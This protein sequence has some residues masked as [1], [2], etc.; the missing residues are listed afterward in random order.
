MFRNVARRVTMTAAVP[1]L[2]LRS[3]TT[4]QQQAGKSSLDPKDSSFAAGNENKAG[5]QP[6]GSD[7][8]LKSGDSLKQQ[9]SEGPLGGSNPKDSNFGASKGLKDDKFSSTSSSGSSGKLGGDLKEPGTK[10]SGASKLPQDEGAAVKDKGS[11]KS[12][13]ATKNRS[14]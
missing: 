4:Q 13:D 10:A 7:K 6:L 12:D 14:Q 8:K 9:S 11:F 5:Q 3:L 1:L 2:G